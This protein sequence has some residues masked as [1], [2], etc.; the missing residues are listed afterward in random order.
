M[1]LNELLKWQTHRKQLYENDLGRGLIA[2]STY[3]TLHLPPTLSPTSSSSPSRLRCAQS[4]QRRTTTHQHIKPLYIWATTSR[5]RS[6]SPDLADWEPDKV[7]VVD[8]WEMAWLREYEELM[9][10]RQENALELA[11]AELEGECLEWKLWLGVRGE[12]RGG[13]VAVWDL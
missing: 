4:S 5:S 6:S 12:H 11:V 9:G 1:E 8:Q 10:A 2:R 7:C 13:E 3:H